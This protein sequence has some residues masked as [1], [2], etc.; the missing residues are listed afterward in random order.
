MASTDLTPAVQRMASTAAAMV[1]FAGTSAL[2]DDLAG[3]RVG[4]KH[5][6]RTAEAIGR[7]IARE[8][9]RAPE[10]LAPAPSRTVYLGLDG[11]G[12]PVRKGETAGRAGKQPDGSARTREAKLVVIWTADQQDE[13]GRPVRDPG[14][15]LYAAAIESA[16]SRDTDPLPS[17]FS[18]RVRREA[19][20]N[21]F[22]AAER[23]VV[24]G[25][26]AA[27]I[28]NLASEQFPRAIQVVDLFHAKERLWDVAKA[29]F[30][31]DAERPGQWAEA[32]C[33]DLN[34]GSFHALLGAIDARA[35]GCEEA[36]KCAAYFRNNRQRMRYP[37]VRTQ[38]L[39]VGSGVVEA[40]CKTVVGDRL[41]RSGMH[42]SVAGANAILALRC[43]YLSGRFEDFWAGRCAAATS[44]PA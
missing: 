22:S 35:G 28:W 38:G 29:L 31:G 4:T 8:E 2:L 34:R 23:Q 19:D 9:A 6:E 30:P 1:S 26:G 17:A 40:G 11:T 20:R 21:G 16:A 18:Q 24:I 15:A 7:E 44:Q 25:D 37:E 43:C 41:K 33:D 36:A 32:R 42:W 10:G 14:S 13:E 39:C 5:V 3:V 27:W 12:I